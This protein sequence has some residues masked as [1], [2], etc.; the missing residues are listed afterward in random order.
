MKAWHIPT[1]VVVVIISA[2]L[3]TLG[4]MKVEEE[5]LARQYR[6]EYMAET[7]TEKLLTQYPYRMRSFDVIKD[8]LAGFRDEELRQVLVRAGAVRWLSKSDIEVWGLLDR[9]I[10]WLSEMKLPVDLDD[11]KPLPDCPL[12]IK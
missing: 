9:N 5:K 8:H 7:A 10:C 2:V 11:P 4:T 6:L 1:T 12:Q 3:T